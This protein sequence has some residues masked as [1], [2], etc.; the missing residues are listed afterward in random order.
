[1]ILIAIQMITIRH[2]REYSRQQGA[3]SLTYLSILKEGFIRWHRGDIRNTL[4]ILWPQLSKLWPQLSNLRPQL[5]N[6]RPQLTKL[7][8]QLNK[9][10]PQLSNLRSQLTNLRPQLSKLWPQLS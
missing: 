8:P 4:F 6:L 5:S 7:W 3:V 10:W 9:L 2:N 1:M